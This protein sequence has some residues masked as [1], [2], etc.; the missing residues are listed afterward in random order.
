MKTSKTPLSINVIYWIT[1]FVFWM[2]IIISGAA[3]IF[4]IVLYTDFFG[5]DLQLHTRFPVKVDI[6]ETGS[7]YLNGR[8]IKVE[9]VEGVTQIH[10]FNTP[11]F[12]ARW[13][14]TALM[15]AC[16]LILYTSFSF[17]KFISNV[18]KQIIFVESNIQHLKN[19]AYALL[20][21]WFFIIV[22]MRIMFQVIGSKLEFEHVAFTDDYPNFAGILMAALFI[23]VLSHI[24]MHGVKLQSEQD[25]TV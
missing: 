25:L 2:F 3:F 10:F 19:M 14:G 18:R 8:N 20:A 4:N 24:F 21:L 15:L 11:L 16:F 5:N 13:I 17:R 9:L 7:L 12:L 23:W 6:L 1:Q 22:Y